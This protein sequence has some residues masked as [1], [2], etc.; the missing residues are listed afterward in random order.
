MK[1]TAIIITLI[2]LML[3]A[4]CVS[5]S[6]PG[7]SPSAV[8]SLPISADPL[9]E[10]APLAMDA[11]VTHTTPNT[12]F[13]V[14][15]DSFE[16]DPVQENGDQELTI[17]L[18]AKNT[19]DKPVMLVWF[20]KL[21]DVNGKTYGGI[22]ISHGGSGARTYW[23]MPAGD[24]T[25]RNSETARDYVNIL[26]DRDLATLAKGAVLDV[27]FMEKPTEDSLVPDVPA[28]H[29]RWTIDPGVIQ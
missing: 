8:P 28:Y 10:G 12:T 18:T 3:A 17:Y 25:M 6:T 16:I 22:K 7:T 27:Y 13:E 1:T 9:T 11:H 19:G 20:C 29:T 26:S 14:W 21:T 15:V 5:Q 23:I 2:T 4:G 24:D